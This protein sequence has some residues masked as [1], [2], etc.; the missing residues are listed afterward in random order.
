[1]PSEP[2]D[3]IASYLTL[4]DLRNVAG[5]SGCIGHSCEIYLNKLDV[6]KQHCEGV[7]IR[8][9]PDGLIELFFNVTVQARHAEACQESIVKIFRYYE[10]T[11]IAF[12]NGLQWAT[13]Y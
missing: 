10:S 6:I 4:S 7:E 5:N 13:R 3:K 12:T 2:T 9:I 1:M 11:D 8:Q